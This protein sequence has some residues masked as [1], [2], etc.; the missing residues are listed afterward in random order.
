MVHADAASIPDDVK[1]KADFYE[2]L[3][4]SLDALLGGQR[5]W[6]SN[7]SNASS[8]IYA[9]LNRFPAWAGS[10]DQSQ[11]P[12]PVN[13]AGFYLLSPFFPGAPFPAKRPTLLLGPFCG[14]PACQQ[15]QSVPGRGVCADASSLLPPRALRV[16]DTDAYPGHIA[17]DSASRSE[18]VVPIVVARSRL[19]PQYQEALARASASA[20]KQAGT[21]NAEALAWGG[22]GDGDEIIV[23]VLDIDCEALSGFD[24]EDERGLTRVAK[25]VSDACDW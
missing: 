21:G 15:I 3:A 23:G 9:S 8:V 24:E 6:V 7:L 25:I 20:D 1:T 4:T 19:S 16:D 5:N 11:A 12:K 18:I 14:L 2:H 17:C 22:R 10:E 13:W